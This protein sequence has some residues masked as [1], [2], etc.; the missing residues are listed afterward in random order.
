MKET[1]K[2]CMAVLGV[3]IIPGALA[4]VVIVLFGEAPIPRL[5]ATLMI[6]G[7]FA[8]LIVMFEREVFQKRK[9]ADA[10]DRLASGVR[11]NG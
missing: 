6:A 1:L 8:S 3:T 4:V 5:A 9:L 10:L 2:F 11:A 7:G